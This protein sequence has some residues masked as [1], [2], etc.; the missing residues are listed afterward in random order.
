MACQKP[1]ASAYFH[2]ARV[3]GQAPLR[4]ELGHG[5]GDE[6][7]HTRT[8]PIFRRRRAESSFDPLYPLFRH[9]APMKQF[10]HF[11]QQRSFPRGQGEGS[12][13]TCVTGNA[14]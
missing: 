14:F 1:S 2:Y 12:S 7:L 3:G 9:E 11:F 10:I 4:R 5:L 13:I 8:I 6:A